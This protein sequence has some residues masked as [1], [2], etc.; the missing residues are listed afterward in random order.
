M[1][2]CLLS[3]CPKDRQLTSGIDLVYL[4]SLNPESVSLNTVSCSH[5]NVDTLILSDPVANLTQSNPVL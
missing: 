4:G 1:I 5:E 2:K 3:V